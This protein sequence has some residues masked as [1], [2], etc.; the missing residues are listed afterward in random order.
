MPVAA[1]DPTTP[2]ARA[3][4]LIRAQDH[5]SFER[6][7]FALATAEQPAPKDAEAIAQVSLTLRDWCV[8]SSRAMRRR[9]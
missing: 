1:L 7:L 6:I 8:R 9:A 5:G 4:R 3:E 2:A